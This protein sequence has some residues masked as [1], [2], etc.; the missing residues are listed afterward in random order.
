MKATKEEMKEEALRRM[1]EW[2]LLL[3]TIRDFEKHE[4]VW[5]SENQ[6][7]PIGI[8]PVLYTVDGYSYEEEARKAIEKVQNNG[9]LPYHVIR[10]HTEM[11]VMY[12]VLYIPTDKEEWEMDKEDQKAGY[13]FSYV[14]NAD[15]PIFSEYGTIGAESHFGGLARTA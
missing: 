12:T 3:E 10:N 8:M 14:Y 1:K 15:E 7:T 11:G 13:S 2:N 9:G 4:N 5:I 6:R